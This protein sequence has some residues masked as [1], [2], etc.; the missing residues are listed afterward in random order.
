MKKVATIWAHS[1]VKKTA[2]INIRPTGKNSLNL[3]TLQKSRQLS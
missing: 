2:Q 3:A 1:I